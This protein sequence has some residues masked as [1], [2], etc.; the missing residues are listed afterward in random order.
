MM[1]HEMLIREDWTADDLGQVSM[2]QFVQ[3]PISTLRTD[4]TK[5]KAT[6]TGWIC[7]DGHGRA[8][9]EERCCREVEGGD[10]QTGESPVNL[11]L[12]KRRPRLENIVY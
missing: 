11:P 4:F 7:D 8:E 1:L 9:C 5:S 6:Q 2:Q 3:T 10:A 12:Y